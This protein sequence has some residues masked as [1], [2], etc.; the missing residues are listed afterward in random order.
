LIISNWSFVRDNKQNPNKIRCTKQDV[1]I[2][3]KLASTAFRSSSTSDRNGDYDF[4]K[5]GW[6]LPYAAFLAL[7]KTPAFTHDFMGK[8][9]QCYNADHDAVTSLSPA[10]LSSA[11]APGKKK[12]DTNIL[13]RRCADAFPELDDD[14]DLPTDKKKKKESAATLAPS[15]RSI[16]DHDVIVDDDDDIHHLEGREDRRATSATVSV[17]SAQQ[18]RFKNNNDADDD[19]DD[20]ED[21]DNGANDFGN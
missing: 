10:T 6:N 18:H 11:A 14:Y 17:S 5:H 7:M 12:P 21:D 16:D 19:D 8:I 13:R 4:D 2:A 20:E 15:L 1:T 3:F 9:Q